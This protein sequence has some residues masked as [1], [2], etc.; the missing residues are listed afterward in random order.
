MKPTRFT[1]PPELLPGTDSARRGELLFSC[2]DGK[3]Y[4]LKELEDVVGKRRQSICESF[5]RNGWRKPRF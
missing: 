5:R 4:T 2:D 3:D 1:G